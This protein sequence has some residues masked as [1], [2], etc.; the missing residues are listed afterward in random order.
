MAIDCDP[1]LSV[2]TAPT[3][4]HIPQLGGGA[5]AIVLAW[6]V[7]SL[8]LFERG[9]T[10]LVMIVGRSSKTVA[11]VAILALT[12]F[13]ALARQPEPQPWLREPPCHRPVV[14]TPSRLPLTF[15]TPREADLQAPRSREAPSRHPPRSSRLRRPRGSE[16]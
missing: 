4:G 5:T 11:F 14:A 10:S 8:L 3:D 6:I 9:T 16:D 12:T 7:R 2:P 1:V 15:S 13:G